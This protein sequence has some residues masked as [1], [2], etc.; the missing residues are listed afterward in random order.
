MTANNDSSIA[1]FI[2]CARTV[3]VNV[4][5]VEVTEAVEKLPK[6]IVE[7]ISAFAGGSDG[8]IVLGIS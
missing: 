7:T 8:T 1:S 3:G 4:Q 6:S 2:S 5:T